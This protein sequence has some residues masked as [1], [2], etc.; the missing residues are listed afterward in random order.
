MKYLVGLMLQNS[1]KSRSQLY[2][3]MKNYQ[4][5]TRIHGI[6]PGHCNKL[7][8]L[9][10]EPMTAQKIIFPFARFAECK[11]ITVPSF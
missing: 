2:I 7:S 4:D 9:P 1:A 10:R 5:F 8:L 3:Q 6:E 11:R